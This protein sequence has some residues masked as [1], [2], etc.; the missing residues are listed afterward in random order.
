MMMSVLSLYELNEQ[1]AG[2]MQFFF[3]NGESVAL[4]VKFPKLFSS[5]LNYIKILSNHSGNLKYFSDVTVIWLHLFK[6]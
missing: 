2:C 5:I 6:M 4:L 3:F 1:A